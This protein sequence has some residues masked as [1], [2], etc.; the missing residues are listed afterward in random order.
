M[1]QD[2]AIR[3]QASA[4]ASQFDVGSPGYRFYALL[5]ESAEDSIKNQLL[6]DEELFD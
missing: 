5:A 3:E 1:P 2:V 4:V 6:M